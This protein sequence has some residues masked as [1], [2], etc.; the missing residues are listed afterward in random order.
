MCAAVYWNTPYL[1]R[2]T[3]LGK[4][5]NTYAMNIKCPI[6]SS[7]GRTKYVSFTTCTCGVVGKGLLGAAATGGN[8]A[9]HAAEAEHSTRMLAINKSGRRPHAQ[10]HEMYVRGAWVCVTIMCHVCSVVQKKICEVQFEFGRTYIDNNILFIA[11]EYF[12]HYQIFESEI[13]KIQIWTNRKMYLI[14]C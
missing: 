5:L 12:F 1:S 10:Q 13:I 3:L 8:T 14:I 2:K 11:G 7:Q 4:T 6:Q 9:L